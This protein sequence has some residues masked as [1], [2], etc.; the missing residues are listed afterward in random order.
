MKISAKQKDLNKRSLLSAA[1]KLVGENGFEDTSLRQISA[2]AGL[3]DPVIYKYF[4]SKSA[5]LFGYLDQSLND[6]LT[7]VAKIPDLEK[8]S[9]A[10]QVQLL[11]QSH[12]EVLEKD[13]GF[14][15]KIFPLV[16]V[17][18]LGTSQESLVPCRTLFTSFVDQCLEEA[19]KAGEINE[20]PFRE[21]LVSVFWD[22]HVGILH[23]WLKD[24]SE[25]RSATSE[26]MQRSMALINEVLKSGFLPKLVDLI[27][28]LIRTHLLTPGLSMASSEHGRKARPRILQETEE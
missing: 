28:F 3:S 1:A 16:F 20:P 8:M 4:P 6:A 27:Y 7:E 24:T 19:I 14:V 26:L 22:F 23:Y 15:T 5:L 25:M 2:E 9:F 12:I 11:M 21:T 13:M 17:T 18:G 10:E